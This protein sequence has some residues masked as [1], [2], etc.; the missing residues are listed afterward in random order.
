M[1]C[2]HEQA[3][4]ADRQRVTDNAR[5]TPAAR[6]YDKD[7]FR[8]RAK[9]IAAHPLCNVCGAKGEHVDHIMTI[10]DHPE[11]RL[12]PTNLRTLCHSCHSRRTAREQRR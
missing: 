7:W 3:R 8:L 5:G 6:G 9:H 10:R 12:D 1:R 2:Q 11:R 4:A